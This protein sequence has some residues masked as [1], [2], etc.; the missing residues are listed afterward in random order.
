[1]TEMN[2]EKRDRFFEAR[3]TLRAQQVASMTL[4][5]AKTELSAAIYAA[6]P[7]LDELAVAGKIFGDGDLARQGVAALVANALEQRWTAR[8]E[9][10]AAKP[11]S[12]GKGNRT[13]TAMTLV[14]LVEAE[15]RGALVAT[16]REVIR[17]IE[18]G[19]TN[20]G[21]G[22][23]GN[24]QAMMDWQINNGAELDVILDALI[25]HYTANPGTVV[26]YY[27]S[28]ITTVESEP[29]S[30]PTVTIED[31][32]LTAAEQWAIVTIWWAQD[33]G[34]CPSFADPKHAAI[35]PIADNL[36]KRNLVYRV[37]HDYDGVQDRSGYALKSSQI[38]RIAS[39]LIE[40]GVPSFIAR[41]TP[42][43]TE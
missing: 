33:V 13:D 22:G 36:T 27:E 16:L 32:T 28:P 18:N 38:E 41:P 37:R 26:D 6:T 17:D 34:I 29:W 21:G 31:V 30:L 12:S 19:I 15:N 14:L 35:R 7:F 25:A 24:P 9:I 5:D 10:V 39:L 43:T 11:A 4:A 23:A 8:E 20:A 2:Q 3:R 40:Q 42:P 1:M